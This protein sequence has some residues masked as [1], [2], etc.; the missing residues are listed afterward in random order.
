MFGK[1]WNYDEIA[2]SFEELFAPYAKKNAT[3]VIE[4]VIVNSAVQFV[5]VVLW[6]N[7]LVASIERVWVH[8]MTVVL[9]RHAESW[10]IVSVHITPVR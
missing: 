4:E 6:K 9:S 3:F 10:A 8:R 7:A 2:A 1:S 5:A